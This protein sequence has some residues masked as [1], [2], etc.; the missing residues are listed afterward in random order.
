MKATFDLVELDE[1]DEDE[2]DKK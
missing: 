2:P 1:K